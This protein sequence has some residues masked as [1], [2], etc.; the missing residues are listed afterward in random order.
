MLEFSQRARGA[1]PYARKFNS[2]RKSHYIL[3]CGLQALKCRGAGSNF[4][5]RLRI[6]AVGARCGGNNFSLSRHITEWARATFRR[7]YPIKHHRLFARA[8]KPGTRDGE[9]NR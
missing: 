7:R 9:I 1:D 3:F 5:T 4:L 8:L 2:S 6:A